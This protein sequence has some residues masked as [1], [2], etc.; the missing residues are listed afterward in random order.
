[1][2]FALKQI[3]EHHDSFSALLL[4]K[5]KIGV[6]VEFA[7]YVWKVYLTLQKKK[8]HHHYLKWLNGILPHM[9]MWDFSNPRDAKPNPSKR[10]RK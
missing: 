2:I 10:E 9:D 1:M 4:D 6:M 5:K 3:I 8:V 7:E